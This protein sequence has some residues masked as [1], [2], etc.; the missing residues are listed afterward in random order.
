MPA[1]FSGIELAIGG[2]ARLIGVEFRLR[3]TRIVDVEGLETAI[4]ATWNEIAGPKPEPIIATFT[5]V[6]R[7]LACGFPGFFGHAWP[8]LMRR[9]ERGNVGG[10][11]VFRNVPSLFID[12][13]MWYDVIHIVDM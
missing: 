12:L 4:R 8:S 2:I 6:F 9:V 11:L 5:N 10:P 1:G 3:H 7:I 13:R